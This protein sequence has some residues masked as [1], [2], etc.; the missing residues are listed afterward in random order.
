MLLKA[1]IAA[2]VVFAGGIGTLRAS[3]VYENYGLLAMGL[4]MAIAG[5]A[6]LSA[7]QATRRSYQA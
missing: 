7:R 1:L 5:M 4:L 3:V 2:I 6:L